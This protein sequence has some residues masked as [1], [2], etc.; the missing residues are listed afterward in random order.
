MVSLTLF[1]SSLLPCLL[2]VCLY[3]W[4]ATAVRE[5]GQPAPTRHLVLWNNVSAAATSRLLQYVPSTWT[6]QWMITWRGIAGTLQK[7]GI[8][9]MWVVVRLLAGMSS[10][11]GLRGASP[12]LPIQLSRL[13]ELWRDSGVARP[14]VDD[15]FC[16]FGGM[17]GQDGD[18]DGVACVGASIS[19]GA[20][21]CI[22]E[23]GHI[24]CSLVGLAQRTSSIFWQEGSG[25]AEF[26]IGL[27]TLSQSP[28]S[29]LP[30][31][32]PSSRLE[33]TA[34]PSR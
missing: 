20:L 26:L 29:R 4:S 17:A 14:A 10:G 31:H 7:E 12:S 13:I 32:K 27:I 28:A 3:I 30:A 18:T 1:F 21:R 2:H 34:L 33:A 6:E 15:E 9:E 16:G 25:L 23:L 5:T 8:D 11:F 22:V 19:L 24:P